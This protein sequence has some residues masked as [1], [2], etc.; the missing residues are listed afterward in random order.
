MWF[1]NLSLFRLP[2]RVSINLKTLEKKL[3][4]ARLRACG[5]LELSTRGFISPFGRNHETISHQVGDFILLT[6]GREDKILPSQV[7]NDLLAEKIEIQTQKQGRR[8]SSKDRKQL[9]EEAITELLPRA[10]VRSSRLMV[11]LDLKNG[12]FI[13]DTAS[14]KAAEEVVTQVRTALGSFP[15][16]PVSVK[17]SPKSHMTNW[18]NRGKLPAGL[19]L[20]D[21][22]ELRDPG[23]AGAVIR[24]RRQDLETDEVREHLKSGKQVFQLGLTFEDRMSFVLDENLVVRKLR[25]LD[26]V[27]D[28]IEKTEF[29]SE[30][31]EIDAHFALM[32]LELDRLLARMDKWFGLP[33]T[34]EQK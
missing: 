16:V 10:F 30:E 13:A 34:T 4:Q 18:L 29:E 14:N 17:T 28:E 23:E 11:Y 5:P 26:F 12:W 1:H 3:T 27:Q 6:L 22:C 32:S 7:V 8:L 21:E 20:G 31:G 2:E 24:C 33:R 25:F 15:V 19:S 9:K